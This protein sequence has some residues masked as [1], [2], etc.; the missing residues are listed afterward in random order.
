MITLHVGPATFKPVTVERIED[1]QM[2][3]EY[4]EIGDEVARA[5]ARTKQAGRRVVA[6]GTTVVRTLETAAR[7]T[8]VVTPMS[9]ESRLFITPGFQFT[10]VDALMTNF[11]LPRTTLVML[12][13]A[14]AGTESMRKVYAEAVRERY[15]FYSYG[16]AMLIL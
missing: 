1:H 4:F 16:D 3:A 13:S 6:V 11:H 14:F 7:E 9:G 2:G 5:I 12:V 8:G 15:R 10:V